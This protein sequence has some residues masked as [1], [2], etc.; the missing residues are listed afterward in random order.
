MHKRPDSAHTVVRTLFAHSEQY[1]YVYETCG[2]ILLLLPSSLPHHAALER[3]REKE[4]TSRQFGSACRSGH[5]YGSVAWDRGRAERR[6]R[7]QIM[8]DK[9]AIHVF[10]FYFEQSTSLPA[11]IRTLHFATESVRAYGTASLHT[12]TYTHIYTVDTKRAPREIS[13]GILG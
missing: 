6:A 2:M 9:F 11:H 7:L 5:E 10:A 4:S 13:F 8:F 12:H 3:G 1:I